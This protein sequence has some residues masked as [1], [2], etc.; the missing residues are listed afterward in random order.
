MKKLYTILIV[1]FIT[2]PCFAQTEYF[3]AYAY[4]SKVMVS[5]QWSEWLDWISTDI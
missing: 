1:I 5:G 2:I 4:S 3:K